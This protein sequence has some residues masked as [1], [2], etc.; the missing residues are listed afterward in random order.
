[1]LS[2]HAMRFKINGAPV[3]FTALVM[4]CLTGCKAKRI[5]TQAVPPV[6]K[7]AF[8]TIT[9]TRDTVQ[10]KTSFVVKNV[11]VSDVRSRYTID[12]KNAKA[13][14][15]LKIEVVYNKTSSVQ[16]ITRHPLFKQLESSS[17]D[18]QLE[19]KSISLLQSDFV[20][21]VPYFEPY[22]KIKIVEVVDFKEQ[23]PVILKNEK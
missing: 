14:S 22:K 12:E 8:Y 17:E 7:T 13:P 11:T 2:S 5:K 1:M 6:E 3:V 10:H 15:Y 21:R 9:A 23:T 4:L 18:G 20:F 19:S 16:A